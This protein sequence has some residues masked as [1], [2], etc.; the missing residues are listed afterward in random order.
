MATE[1]AM[2]ATALVGLGSAALAW[3]S[4]SQSE[5][6]AMASAKAM[7]TAMVMETAT[8]ALG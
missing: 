7:E 4:A 8:R 2:E 1:T 5:W 3:E 6:M